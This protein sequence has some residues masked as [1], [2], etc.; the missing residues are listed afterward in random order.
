MG[1]TPIEVSNKNITAR[2]F[3]ALD[4]E[5]KMAKIIKGKLD[6]T[7]TFHPS[8]LVK[9]IKNIIGK[10]VKELRIPVFSFK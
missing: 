8:W 7:Q 10:P 6:I 3:Q 2:K 9:T 1:T 5:R 4:K